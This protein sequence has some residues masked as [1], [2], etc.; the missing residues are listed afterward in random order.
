MT[1]KL[2]AEY[3]DATQPCYT[4]NTGA[5]GMFANIDLFFDLLKRF[6]LGCVYLPKPSK[7]L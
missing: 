1:Q 5:L 3:T 6:V 7:S 4:G 2:K